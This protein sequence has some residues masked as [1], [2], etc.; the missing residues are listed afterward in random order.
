MVS[1]LILVMA[2]LG[3][4]QFAV[5]QWRAIWVTAADHRLSQSFSAMTAVDERAIGASDFDRLLGLCDQF[6]PALRK[7]S[8]WLREVN[9]YYRI[10]AILEKASRGA[11]P[12]LAPWLEQEMERC[13]RYVAFLLDQR[14]TAPSVAAGEIQ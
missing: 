14:L 8:P 9:G 10:V 13:S 5:L 4:T 3:L 11:L 2:V 12:A 6:C 7:S 1:S